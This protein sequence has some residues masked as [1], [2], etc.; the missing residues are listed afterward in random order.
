MII[1][2]QTFPL[3]KRTY[4][5]G[6]LNVTPDS[7]SDGG[8]YNTVQTAVQHAI[9]MAEN[10][11]DLLD[12]GG[13]STRP[14]HQQISEEEEIARVTPVIQAVKKELPHLPLSIDT[15]KPSVCRAAL[16]AGADWIND[17]WGFQFDPEM[18]KIA[19]EYQVPCCLMH[20]RTSSQYE[21]FFPDFLS[22][23]QKCVDTALFYGV[24]KENIIL[25]P[26][27]GFGK[28]YDQN[29]FVMNHLEEIKK[30]LPYPLLLGTSRKSMIGIALGEVPP[31]ERLEGTL[32]TTAIGIMKGCDFI[33]V[34]NIKENKQVCLM[35]D[36]IQKANQ[37]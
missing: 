15:Y 16:E 10:G 1:G 33:R 2:N 12:I 6:I 35:S 28:T 13:E 17:I 11:A 5:M 30:V 4:L 31:E 14:G 21:N 37:I 27:I 3:G 29:L 32:A 19:S 24:K 23:L 36:A 26:G 25:D 9:A 7:F 34:H 22:D 8:R 20:N 18:A